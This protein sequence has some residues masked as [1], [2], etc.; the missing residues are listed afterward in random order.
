MTRIIS[1]SRIVDSRWAIHETG[2]ALHQIHHRFLDQDFRSGIHGTCG[3]IQDQDLGVG[4]ESAGDRQQLFLS[5]RNVAGLFVQLQVVAVRQCAH[6][7]VD[8]SGLGC[9]YHRVIAGVKVAVADI[10]P[11]SAVE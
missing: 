1:A 9:R 4:Q 8:V 3:L 2:P 11:D 10:L 5:L 6:K 7:M